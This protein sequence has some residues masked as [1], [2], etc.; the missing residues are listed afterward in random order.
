MSMWGSTSDASG[1]DASDDTK[2]AEKADGAATPLQAAAAR[3][4]RAHLFAYYP[5]LL[6][7]AFVPSAPSMWVTPP[8]YYRLFGKDVADDAGLSGLGAD[9]DAPRQSMD[10]NGDIGPERGDEDMVEVSARE[11]ARRALELVGEELCL[12]Q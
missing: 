9:E 4:P 12:G 7:L 1:S 8:E 10:V 2:A 6:Q 3:S 5:L 11:L